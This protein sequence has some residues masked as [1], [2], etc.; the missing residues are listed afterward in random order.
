M[1]TEEK[2]DY[3]SLLVKLFAREISEDEI[4]LLQEW[5]NS[6]PENYQIFDQEN[7]LWQETSVHLKKAIYDPDDSWKTL[8]SRLAIGKNK[9]KPIYLSKRSN[10]LFLIAAASVA[11]MIGIGGIMLWMSEKTSFQQV[12]AASTIFATQKGEKA[13]LYLSDSTEI[14]LNS[15]SR[16]EYSGQYN[17]KSRN[18]KFT[19]EAYFNVRTNPDK[20]FVVQLKGMKVCA[21]GT[22][23]NICSYA[24][25][26]RIE[27]TL[28]QGKIKVSINGNEDLNI[29]A[30]QQVVYFVQSKKVKIQDID[31]DTYSSWKDDKLRFIEAP[32]DEVIRRIGRKYNVTFEI[33]NPEILKLK[34]TATLLDEPIEEV[35]QM[36]SEISSI[37]YK[38]SKPALSVDNLAVKPKIILGKKAL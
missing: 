19:G 31:M 23:F 18:V 4:L 14:I 9:I 30:G 38:I 37:N 20:P 24:D 3:H 28:E 8:S 15:E 26:D 33:T 11:L 27:T 34:F 12:A 5:L 1:K 16:L 10:F 22:R 29:K 25:D 17:L 13:H 32:L 36:F 21:T 2:I 6:D 7:E 35:M